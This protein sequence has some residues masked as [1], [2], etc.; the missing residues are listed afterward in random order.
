MPLREFFLL[1][2]AEN[3]ISA[4][5][6]HQLAR[7]R[8]HVEAATRRLEAARRVSQA[9]PA[10]ELLQKAVVHLLSARAAASDA[11]LDEPSRDDL[12]RSLPE[13][14]AA[15]PGQAGRAEDLRRAR[16]AL[17]SNDPLYLDRLP[18]QDAEST[19]TGL[20]RLAAFLRHRVE[21]RDLVHVRAARWGRLAACCLV[22][23][24]A[25]YRAVTSVVAP[26]N[27][28]LN[29]PVTVSSYRVNPPDG[30]E[31]VD[32]SFPLS[33]AVQTDR[34]DSPHIVI[35]LQAVYRIQTIKVYNRGDGWQD[36]GLPIAVELSID[37][38]YY[39]PAGRREMHFERDPP[40][41]IHVPKL[42]AR[43][44]RLRGEHAKSYLAL[45][46]VEVFGRK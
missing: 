28:A 24:Y 33:Y 31:L 19:R 41:V 4:Y 44:V 32:G 12:L 23:M 7:I 29:K 26:S 6:P 8:E 34:E 35:D 45:S 17:C 27:L 46:Q 2:Q 36:E 20:E 37:G 10:S 43:Y 42:P 40:W 14:V 11:R 18:V 25:S 39:Y 3:V 1:E 16:A 13:V 9:A 5:T 15:G 38:D 30:H 22:A 21:A